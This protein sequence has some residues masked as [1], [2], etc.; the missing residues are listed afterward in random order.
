M[1]VQLLKLR[2]DRRDILINQIV[3]EVLLWTTAFGFAALAKAMSPENSDL[4]REVFIAQAVLANGLITLAQRILHLRRQFAELGLAEL[5]NV[6][7][8]KHNDTVPPEHLNGHKHYFR[9]LERVIVVLS[10]AGL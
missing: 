3:Q 8:F 6:D 7:R 4:V 5:V 10:T 2:F 1:L 9:R